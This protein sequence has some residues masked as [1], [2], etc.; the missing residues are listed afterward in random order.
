MMTATEIERLQRIEAL[1]DAAAE[2]PPGTAREAFLS[3]Q[4]AGLLEEVRQLLEDHERVCAAAPEPETLPQFGAWRA[5]RLLGR[6][7]MGTVYLAERSDGVFRMQA[8]VKVV[9]LALAS[10][11][12]E[13]RFRRERQFLASLDHPKVAR[14]IDGGV[15][16]S[17]LPYLVMEFVDGL[18]ID[19][20]CDA[21]DLDIR[22]KVALMRQVLEALMYVHSRQVIHRDLKPSNI[23]VDASGNVKLLDFGTARLVDVSGDTAI[24]RT[25]VFAFTPDCASPEQVQGKP[26]TFASDIYSAGVLLYRLLT[27]KPPYRFADY[28]PAAVANK[29]THIDPEPSGLEAPLDAVLSAALRK[30]PEQR[31]ASA[32]EMDADLARYLEGQPVL[33]R[34]PRKLLRIAMVAAAIILCAAVGWFSV[35][36]RAERNRESSVVPLVSIAVLPFAN[37]S[38]APANQY[39]SDGLTDEITDSLA[40]VKALRVIARSSTSQ[41]KGKTENVREIGRSLGV[42]NI[43]E[44]SVERSGDRVKII[45]QL[46]RVSDGSLVWSNTYERKASDLFAVQSELAAGITGGLKLAAG[47]PSNAHIPNAEAHE[48]VMRGNYEV[49]QT[50]QEAVAQAELDFQHAIDQDP[51]YGAAYLGLAKA[52]YDQS[53]ARGNTPQ[54]EAELKS[55]EQLA[56]E[57]LARDPDLPAAHGM[58]ALLAIQYHQDW[59]RAERELSAITGPPNGPSEMIYG[60]FLLFRGRLAEADRHFSRMAELDPFSIATQS[61]LALARLL[62]GRFTECRE[63][64][65]KAAAGSP[66]MLWTQ[67]MIGLTYIEEGHPELA[68]P[69][70]LQ[71]KQRWPPA[72]ALEAMALARSGR[73]E[74]ALRLIRPYEDA[75]PSPIA[76]EWLAMVYAFMGDEPNTV[77]WLERSAD[78]HETQA[79]SLAVDPTFAP[80]RN[81]PGFRALEKRMG[82]R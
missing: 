70:F 21:Q 42:T 37:L 40:R 74:E 62:E 66:K 16:G 10:L 4:D 58:L 3:R 27:G 20:Y 72:A 30:H 45:A 9:P 28:S 71:L 63:I 69:I 15:T 14:L 36:R 53:I 75:Y 49:N 12:I 59:S 44:G 23:L 48:F 68:L 29:I 73:K 39:F 78:L 79:L 8:A 1:F 54:S 64:S 82:L 17:G 50:T 38:G 46:E 35:D 18:T 51:D 34:R 24:T 55:V 52:K 7:G 22:D 2:Y 81:S 41:F 80:M 76:A 6:G 19:R 32:A 43:L 31:Y 61:N 77:R 67:Q 5:V 47:V 56:Q 11:E 13:E 65:Q 57:A 60:F 25:G 26:L 33:A